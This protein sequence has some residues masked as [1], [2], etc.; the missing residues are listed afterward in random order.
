MT[1]PP[2]LRAEDATA[3]LL[4]LL[5][6]SFH[7]GSMARRIQV[8]YTL[9][10]HTQVV[11]LVLRVPPICVSAFSWVTSPAAPLIAALEHK[12]ILHALR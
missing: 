6:P 5:V 3:A 10:R 1:Q 12:M 9:R 4:A 2:S 8:F 11:V 7:P